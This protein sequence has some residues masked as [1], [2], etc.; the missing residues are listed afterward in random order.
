MHTAVVEAL[1]R[2]CQC[3][4][5]IA[6]IWIVGLLGLWWLWLTWLALLL[7]AA[8][9]L[10]LMAWQAVVLGAAELFLWSDRWWR[11][12]L[13]RLLASGPLRTVAVIGMGQ[14]SR[15]AER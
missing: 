4:P 2:W 10:L 6:L 13:L 9:T 12:L 3:W 1:W 8:G 15:P 5:L 7:Y 11:S 14:P